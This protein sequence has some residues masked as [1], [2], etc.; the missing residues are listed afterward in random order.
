MPRPTP[1]ERE[2]QIKQTIARLFAQKGYH[3]TS[4]REA[5]RELGMTPSSLYNYFKS[6]EDLLFA[7]MNEAVDEALDVLE[8]IC[9]GPA[10]AEEK[11]HQVLD[12]YTRYYTGDQDK[13]TLLVNEIQ[14]LGARRYRILRDKERRYVRLIRII[15]EELGAEGKMKPMDHTVAAF[16]FFG[17][18][19]Y[20]IKWYHKDGPIPPD[21]LA[22]LFIEIFT[23]GIL[24]R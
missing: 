23:R 2:N 20:T 22:R 13:L 17:M 3:A 12:F 5:A 6:K 4:M 14:S 15:F 1:R 11:L 19:H 16:S 21:A 10:P 18:V 9:N 8:G 24:S 7:L